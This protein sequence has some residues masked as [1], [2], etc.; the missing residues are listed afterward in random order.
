[1]AV[2]I[3]YVQSGEDLPLITVEEEAGWQ[4]PRP[5]APGP[6]PALAVDDGDSLPVIAAVTVDEDPGVQLVPV[7]VAPKLYRV[8]H[9]DEWVEFV[10]SV[11][12][13][14]EDYNTVA[15]QVL[16]RPPVTLQRFWHDD[17]FA[18]IPVVSGAFFYGTS[19]RPAILGAS[20]QPAIL[21][22]SL[23]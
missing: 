21:G 20:I 22:K 19:I 13:P 12:G 2:R 15:Y 18:G 9:T 11:F 8:P 14:E 3:R 6:V 17:L 1:V 23:P 16:I 4:P 10:P 7:L 5:V